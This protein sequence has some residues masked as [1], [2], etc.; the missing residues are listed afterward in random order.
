[1]SKTLNLDYFYGTEAEQYTFYRIPKMLFTD[2]RFKNISVDAKML[3]GLMLDRMG[4]SMKNNW[5]DSNNKVFIYFTLEDAIEMLGYG[6][7]K[8]I[9]ILS[10][11]DTAKGIG[12]IERKKQG[13][14]KPTIIYV[15]SFASIG[16]GNK[17]TKKEDKKSYPKPNF[18]TSQNEK[19]ET[20]EPQNAEEDTESGIENFESSTAQESFSDDE[21]VCGNTFSS[22]SESAEVLTSQNRKS[23]LHEKGSLD[24]SNADTNNTNSSNTEF[25]DIKSIYPSISP[26][27]KQKSEKIEL[28]GLMDRI[29]NE[30]LKDL[31]LEELYEQRTLPYEYVMDERKMTIAIHEFTEYEHYKKYAD[32]NVD[33]E[34][35]FSVIK[36]FNEALIEM[37]TNRNPMTLKGA[38]VTYAKVYD[39]LVTYI[40][41][42]SDIYG[43]IYSLQDTA[44]G[45]FTLACKEQS[46][47]NH[48]AYM[49]SC[50]WNAM[51]VGDIGI[52]ALIK[53]DFG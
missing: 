20:V 14:G 47:K 12:L 42:E 3:Y 41:F 43:S 50:I 44:V 30:D 33:E 39:K 19:S 2:E 36:L 6:H 13:Q 18:K 35:R 49:K 53:K 23:A 15:K 7:T 46:I 22:F 9:K 51:Q 34:F 38:Y 17:P 5:L 28:D 26:Y 32:L 31:V 16:G 21:S 11:L 48:L 45:D 25:S 52:Q 1:M 8:V 40:S 4:L 37:L 10:E 29:S 27:K 24:F